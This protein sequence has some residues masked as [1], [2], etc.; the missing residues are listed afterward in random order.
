MS[1]QANQTFLISTI[2]PFLQFLPRLK[3]RQLLGLDLNLFPCFRITPGVTPILLNKEWTQSP[4]FYS[5]PIRQC[6]SHSIEKMSTTAAASGLD[7]SVASFNAWISSSLFIRLSLLVVRLRGKWR[8]GIRGRIALMGELCQ[9][10][11]WLWIVWPAWR[12]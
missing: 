2:H 4:D 8:V 6:V 10:I 11:D 12:R 7:R 3:E 9:E 1:V 5:I